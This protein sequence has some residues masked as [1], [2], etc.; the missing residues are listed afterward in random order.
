[1][2]RIYRFFA[3]VTVF[4]SFLSAPAHAALGRAESSI[5]ADQA[6]LRAFTHSKTT[7]ENF[8]RHELTGQMNTVTEY[9]DKSGLV[10]AVTW[11][12][13][14]KPDL[15][16]L[17]GSYFQEYSDVDSARERMTIRHP[18]HIQTPNIVVTKEGH[19]RDV[20]G[21][22]YL[23]GHVPSGVNLGDLL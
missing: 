20:R 18:V 21:R 15:S 17:L 5:D 22:A 3:W 23:P 13:V 14:L 12:G 16:T 19:M 10:F 2:S 6:S 8:T 7:S 9:V 1:M 4:V 11:H